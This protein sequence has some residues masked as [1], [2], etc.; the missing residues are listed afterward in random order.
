M[1]EL[2]NGK[3]T[4]RSQEGCRGVALGMGDGACPG[5]WGVLLPPGSS[6]VQRTQ[7]LYR[8]LWSREEQVPIP[9]CPDQGFLPDP[10]TSDSLFLLIMRL[11]T[12]QKG[13]P[14]RH[15]ECDSLVATQPSD[16]Q[17]WGRSAATQ[18]QLS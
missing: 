17:G 3:V 11:R 12:R 5:G 8:L 6:I 4:I 10:A 9:V 18:P 2:I 7:S 16:W 14:G 1:R 15:G 13:G